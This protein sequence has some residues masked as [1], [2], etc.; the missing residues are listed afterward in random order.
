MAEIAIH[1]QRQIGVLRIGA[2]P[3]TGCFVVGPVLNDLALACPEA[4]LELKT[5]DQSHLTRALM[6]GEIDLI[7]GL[8]HETPDNGETTK[9]PLVE[10]PYVVVARRE[11]PLSR[12]RGLKLAD[13]EGY[14]WVAPSPNAARRETFDRLVETMVQRPAA[15]LQASS[16][17]TLRLLVSG[18]DRLALLTRFEFEQER[19]EGGLVD[20]DFGPI[21]P[22]HWLGIT[23]RSNWMPAPLHLQ[24]ASLMRDRAKHI[25]RQPE[26]RSLAIAAE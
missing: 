19:Q 7:I 5:G 20:L 22:A 14:D 16:L 25:T 9:E 1:L 6:R 8:L 24:F 15:N 12:L 13:L 18:S 26:P 10:L 23:T 11:H 17:S 2:L 4:R 3:M 21:T